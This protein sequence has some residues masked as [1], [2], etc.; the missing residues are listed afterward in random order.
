MC[1]GEVQLILKEITELKILNEHK[2]Y[3]LFRN[4]CCK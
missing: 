2:L 1:E 4:M 3:V